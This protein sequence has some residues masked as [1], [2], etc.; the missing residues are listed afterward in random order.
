MASTMPWGNPINLN[1][2]AGLVPPVP[3]WG[4]GGLQFF[5]QCFSLHTLSQLVPGDLDYASFFTAQQ[6]VNICRAAYEKKNWNQ[7]LYFF[8]LAACRRE[9][10]VGP[11]R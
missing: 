10:L 4:T 9:R 6:A 2:P 11:L 3:D 5:L 1:D 8:E 7:Y